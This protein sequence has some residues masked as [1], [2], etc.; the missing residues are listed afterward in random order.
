ME[1]EI[2]RSR[3]ARGGI[4]GSSMM[5]NNDGNMCCLGFLAMR[6]GY[7]ASDLE[8]RPSPSSVIGES[9]RGNMFP[10]WITLGYISTSAVGLRLMQINDRWADDAS[11]EDEITRIMGEHGVTVTFVD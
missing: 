3:W 8:G 11:R 10:E 7:E 1:L 6:C 5:R 2:I 4:N 9:G